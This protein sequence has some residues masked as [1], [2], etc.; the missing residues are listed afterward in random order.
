MFIISDCTNLVVKQL[1]EKCEFFGISRIVHLSSVYL[2]SSVYWPNIYGR[3]SFNY[4]FYRKEVPFPQYCESKYRSE[5][6][7]EEISSNK[8]ILFY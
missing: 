3:E 5:Q 6:I 1:T 4:K 2:Q 7:L 8:K